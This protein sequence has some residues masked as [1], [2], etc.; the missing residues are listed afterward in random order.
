MEIWSK[1]ERSL[2]TGIAIEEHGFKPKVMASLSTK[3]LTPKTRSEGI[4][5]ASLLHV[6]QFSLV[7][8]REGF[9]S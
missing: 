2:R 3:M 6:I 5:V 1:V 4:G 7:W 9:I 8:I